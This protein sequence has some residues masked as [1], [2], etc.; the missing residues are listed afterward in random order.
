MYP[1]CAVLSVG[2]RIPRGRAILLLLRRCQA[3]TLFARAWTQRAV[4]TVST[5]RPTDDPVRRKVDR[6]GLIVRQ[7]SV[8]PKQLS[9]ADHGR[10][11]RETCTPERDKNS[12][13]QAWLRRESRASSRRS[14]DPL[15]LHLQ[16]PQHPLSP[17]EARLRAWRH[18]WQ[19]LADGRPIGVF[20]GPLVQVTPRSRPDG[21]RSP[22]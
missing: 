4:R 18:G 14:G 17:A 12:P 8:I 21:H 9:S 6:M 2:Q 10:P 3:C 13:A 20:R 7:D 5:T 16:P 15:D 1:S 11:T 19:P 22:R